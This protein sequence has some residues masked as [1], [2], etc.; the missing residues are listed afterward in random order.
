MERTTKRDNRNNK[1]LAKKNRDIIVGVCKSGAFQDCINIVLKSDVLHEK[2]LNN[3][4]FV[5][6]HWRTIINYCYGRV[7]NVEITFLTN[8]CRKYYIVYGI[9]SELTDFADL[10]INL[11]YPQPPI[12]ITGLWSKMQYSRRVIKEYSLNIICNCGELC[13]TNLLLPSFRCKNCK[14]Y[15]IV[16]RREDVKMTALKQWALANASYMK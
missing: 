16:H 15:D 11:V 13:C 14:K 5:C 2:D 3:A 8:H 4:C 9:I 10:S 6:K 1:K 7:K 12:T